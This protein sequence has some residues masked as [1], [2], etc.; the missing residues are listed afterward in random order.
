[1][2]WQRIFLDSFSGS[3]S[4]LPKRQRTPENVL[5]AL[6]TNPRVSTWEM[7]EHRWLRDCIYELEKAG[8]ITS[9]TEPYPWCKYQVNEA[10]P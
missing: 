7:S 3:A 10:Q 6:R 9:V 5:A 1:M 2:R 4:D 8:R